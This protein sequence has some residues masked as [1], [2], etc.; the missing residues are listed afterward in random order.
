MLP[1][2]VTDKNG[3]FVDDLRKTTSSSGSGTPAVDFDTFERD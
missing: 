3:K 1:V 2:L